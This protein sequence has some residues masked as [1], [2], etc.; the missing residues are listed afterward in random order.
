MPCIGCTLP[1]VTGDPHALL[2]FTLLAN[3]RRPKYISIF[4]IK[5]MSRAQITGPYNDLLPDPGQ[6]H[7]FTII[8]GKVANTWWDPNFETDQG[9]IANFLPY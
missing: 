7:H 6:K 3:A 2:T 1:A 5:A 9:G 4:H 8:C